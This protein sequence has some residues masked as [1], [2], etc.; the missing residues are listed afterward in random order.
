MVRLR[1]HR[2][3]SLRGLQWQYKTQDKNRLHSLNRSIVFSGRKQGLYQQIDHRTL[4]FF[5]THRS[6]RLQFAR[7]HGSSNGRASRE[8]RFFVRATAYES[9]FCCRAQADLAI[10]FFGTRSRSS[11]ERACWIGDVRSVFVFCCCFLMFVYQVKTV[12]HIS[13]YMTSTYNSK[14]AVQYHMTPIYNST[15]TTVQYRTFADPLL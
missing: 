13:L 8:I 7:L 10:F 2:N 4:N 11:S 15:L 9:H 6:I 3:E 14:T 5:S 12:P 1:A